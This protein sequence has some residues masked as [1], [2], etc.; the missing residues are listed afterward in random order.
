MIAAGCA[1]PPPHPVVVS[2]MLPSPVVSQTE[3]T[4]D[5]ELLKSALEDNDGQPYRVGPGDTLL[6][7]VYNHPELAVA[8]YGGGSGV[9]VNG[10]AARTSGL[11][12]DTDG[13]IQFPLIGTVRVAGKSSEELRVIPERR[14]W[15]CSSKN[16]RSPF[17]SSTT[18]ASGI[19]CWASSS[20]RA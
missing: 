10:T 6:V 12:I 11:Y 7:A 1:A 3:Q 19:T 9:A 20:A 18:E 5:P 2:K 13:S 4:L 15:R 14:S 17:R 16:R 8:T